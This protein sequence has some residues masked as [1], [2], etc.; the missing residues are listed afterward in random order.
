MQK[1]L[2]HNLELTL[3][4]TV[5]EFKARY[6]HAALGFLWIILNP[7]FQM[8]V[9]GTIFSYFVKIPNY[10]LFLFTNLLPWSFFSTSLNKVTPSFVN[11][12]SLLQKSKFFRGA[13]PI[14]IIFSNFV[15]LL[16]SIFLL[17]LF[18]IFTAQF[19]VVSFLVIIP[20]L[21]W[22]LIF[23]IGFSFL[24]SSLN[25]RFRDINFFVQ[26]FLILWFY[27]TPI[28]YNFSLVPQKL[29]L[30]FSF[31]PLASILELFRFAVFEKADFNSLIVIGNILISIV[32]VLLGIRVYRKQHPYFVDWL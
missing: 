12:R 19:S 20:A 31:N 2:K 8:I 23:T 15:H 7:L 4:L 13:I 16:I 17:A 27:A 22:L 3:S 24:S 21:A 10:Y 29:I 26:S 18:L 25:V 32:I 5:K 28:L 30:F 1:S 11:E 6:K 14:S 9:I